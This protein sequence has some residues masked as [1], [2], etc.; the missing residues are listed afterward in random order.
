MSNITENDF[1]ML[2][3][4]K[5]ESEPELIDIHEIVKIARENPEL[6][7]NCLTDANSYLLTN[8]AM[9]IKD[10][11][12][13]YREL[14]YIESVIQTCAS[15]RKVPSSNRM[16]FL[17]DIALSL[18]E[19]VQ[20][21]NDIDYERLVYLQSAMIQAARYYEDRCFRH[22]DPF[23]MNTQRMFF[24]ICQSIPKAPPEKRYDLIN[25]W[26]HMADEDMLPFM[27]SDIMPALSDTDKIKLGKRFAELNMKKMAKSLGWKKKSRKR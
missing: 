23:H 7:V 5:E 17:Y 27:F 18:S 21:F 3:P 20:Q 10:R 6:F 25:R 19:M 8:V 16:H 22:G 26:L 11:E 15:A 14:E 24:L 9:V 12:H 13:L 2:Q 1:D 4:E